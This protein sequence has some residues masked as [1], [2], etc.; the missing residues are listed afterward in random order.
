MLALF[1]GLLVCGLLLLLTRRPKTT[2]VDRV[3]SFSSPSRGV[4]AASRRARG[5][6]NRSLPLLPS[7]CCYPPPK[8]T[9]VD[10]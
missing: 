3:E 2:V 5:H 1:F 7:V 9:L 6:R 10:R 4:Q 8:T